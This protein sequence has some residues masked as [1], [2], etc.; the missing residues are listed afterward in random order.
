MKPFS[1]LL[2]LL[3]FTGCAKLSTE[4]QTIDLQLSGDMLFSGA[5]TLQMPVQTTTQSLAGS[6]NLEENQLKNIGLHKAT[7]RL[8]EEQKAITESLLLQIVSAN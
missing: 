6:L 5:N 3:V 4:T 7:I 1:F 8:T 2:L